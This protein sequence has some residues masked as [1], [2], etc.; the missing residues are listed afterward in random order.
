MKHSRLW[1]ISFCLLFSGLLMTS[2]ASGPVGKPGTDV[3]TPTP[4]VS[5]PP[6]AT[7]KPFLPSAP[8]SQFVS[9]LGTS[10]GVNLP[11]VAAG[12]LRV[13]LYSVNG[14]LQFAAKTP[15][16]PISGPAT[17]TGNTLALGKLAAGAM[18]CAGE[19]SAQEQ[20]VTQ[21]LSRPI[22]MSFVQDTL[23]WTSGGDT[24]RFKT[25]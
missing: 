10:N 7:C 16:N 1:Q 4:N 22:E 18:G 8:C 19:S 23:T 14:V 17:I 6:L 25:K 3:A 24:L 12:G 5:T 2:C 11:W 13:E 9:I 15:C 20:W 21:F